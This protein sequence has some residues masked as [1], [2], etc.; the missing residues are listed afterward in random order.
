MKD[1]V[2]FELKYPKPVPMVHSLQKITL[3]FIFC[4]LSFT[5]FAQQK[6]NLGLLGG[7]WPRA[8]QVRGVVFAAW[9]FQPNSTLQIE[10]GYVGR[11]NLS[12]RRTWPDQ[13]FAFQPILGYWEATAAWKFHFNFPQT[14]VYGLVAPALARGFAADVYLGDESGQY[15]RTFLDWDALE[16]KRFEYGAYLGFGLE[17]LGFRDTKIIL[18]CRYYLGFSDI[19]LTANSVFNQG[20]QLALGFSVPISR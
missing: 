3:V 12:W 14:R 16:I 20:P 15:R 18:D 13:T 19:D 1:G 4:L 9:D 7:G 8:L 6:L 5:I 11:E 2:A 17:H 10:M